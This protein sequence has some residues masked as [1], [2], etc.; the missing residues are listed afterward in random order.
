[1]TKQKVLPLLFLC[2]FAPLPSLSQTV[3]RVGHFPNVTHG[4]ALLGRANGAFEKALGP[5]VKVQWKA[6]NAGPSVTEALFAGELDVAYVGPSP[7]V[8]AYVRSQGDALRVIAGGTSGGAA[9]VVRA[10]SAIQKPEDFHGKRVASPQFGNTQD[11]A[12]R[13]WLAK[14]GLKPRERGG[15]VQITPIAN[16]D[17]LTLFLQKQLDAAWAPEP[18]AARLVREAGG[19]LLVDERSEWPNGQFASTLVIVSKKFLNQHPELVK[20]WLSAH[21]DLTNWINKN[22]ADAERQINAE[23]ARETGK[24]L[25]SAVIDDSFSRLDFTVDPIRCSIQT[26]AQRAADLGLFGGKGPDIS[27]LFDLTLLNQVMAEKHLKAVQ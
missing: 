9:L 6:F 1:M 26:S 24:G 12:L 10:G 27:G 19:R 14:H 21:V 8:T 23:I 17:Q 5:Q 13:D 18:W 22:K 25:T 16:P 7:A 20:H 3:I 2:F 4:Q 15:D 11:I